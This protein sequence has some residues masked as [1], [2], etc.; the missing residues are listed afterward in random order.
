MIGD[1]T[2]LFSLPSCCKDET[3]Q[4][5]IVIDAVCNYTNVDLATDGDAPRRR[6]LSGM[7]KHVQDNGM[8]MI[9]KMP[10]FDF[11]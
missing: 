11:Y 4:F 2:P 1:I 7:M 5:P 3:D 8:H 10:L 9:M 6:I